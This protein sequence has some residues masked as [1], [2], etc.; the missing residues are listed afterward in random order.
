[1]KSYVELTLLPDADIA[2]YFLWSKVYQQIHLALVESKDSDNKTAIGVSF[3]QYHK[4]EGTG[5]FHLGSKL[6]LFAESSRQL[7][8][9]SLAKWLAR[10]TDY[11]H[12]TSIRDV[13]DKVDGYAVFRR[14]TDKRNYQ[15]LAKRRAKRLGVS[16]EEA[17][18]YFLTDE[19]RKQPEKDVSNYPFIKIK[20]LSG[21][22]QMSLIVAR[23]FRDVHLS[24]RFSTYGFSSESTV[25]IF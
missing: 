24:N 7:A 11:V 17:L 6:R 19:E 23:E 8:D 20:S 4:D 13:P 10:L 14:L 9:L 15:R 25:P 18:A 5:T 21:N 2:L 1:M 16:Y 22:H 12:I 3:P